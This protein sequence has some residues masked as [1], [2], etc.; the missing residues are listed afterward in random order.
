VGAALRRSGS[1]ASGVSP[2][3]CG[4]KVLGLMAAAVKRSTAA[5][6]RPVLNGPKCSKEGIIRWRFRSEQP[7]SV[8]TRLWSRSGALTI[9]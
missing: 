4:V 3:H 1:K 6:S 5:R 2:P 8:A 9:A 7:S